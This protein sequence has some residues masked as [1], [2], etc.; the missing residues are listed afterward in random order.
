MIRFAIVIATCALVLIALLGVRTYAGE[1]RV[2]DEVLAYELSPNEPLRVRVPGGI[3]ELILTSWAVVTPEPRFD[4]RKPYRYTLGVELKGE[5]PDATPAQSLTLESRVS[6][7][8]ARPLAMGDFTARL[9]NS[10]E[11]LA[12]PRSQRLSLSALGKPGGFAVVRARGGPGVERV[13]V[14]LTYLEPLGKLEKRVRARALRPERG[15]RM[16]AGRSS[17]GFDDLPLAVRDRALE[18]WERRFPAVGREG[19][20][21]V[22]GSVLIGHRLPLVTAE[23]APRDDYAVGPLVRTGLNFARPL[24]LRLHGPPLAEI[25]VTEGASPAYS[26]LIGESGQADLALKGDSP[27]TISFGAP[28]TARLRFSVAFGD[29]RAQIGAVDSAL[30]EQ[31]VFLSPDVRIQRYYE[32]DPKQPVV[33][34]LAPGQTAVGLSVRAFVDGDARSASARISSL[35]ADGKPI[36]FEPFVDELEASLFDRVKERRVTL[37]RHALLDAPAGTVELAVYGELGTL[38][39]PFVREPGVLE[40]RPEADYDIELPEGMAWRHA[41]CID[42]VVAAVRAGNDAALD[43]DGRAVRVEATVRLEAE[44]SVGPKVVE[45]GA[46]PKGRPLVRTAFLP[47]SRPNAARVGDIWSF[48]PF[49]VPTAVLVPRAADSEPLSVFYRVKASVL[50]QP[51]AFS[52]DGKIVADDPVVVRSGRFRTDAGPGR[53][54]LLLSGADAGAGQAIGVAFASALSVKGGPVFQRRSVYE[55]AFG[56]ALELDFERKADEL[57]SLFVTVVREAGPGPVELR[58]AIDPKRTTPTPRKMYRRV[59]DAKGTAV[60]HALDR[61]RALLLEAEERDAGHPLPHAVAR[62]R[63]ELGDDLEVG[64]HVLRLEAPPSGKQAGSLW[65]RAVVAGRT[66][67]RGVPGAEEAP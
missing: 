38:V 32:L 59:T 60:I 51:L 61:D 5:V 24:G 65:V 41:P 47:S 36:A 52:V 23:G 11:W 1:D 64:E 31:R 40:D 45:R 44:H 34:R 10:E 48:L 16:V 8:P 28:A 55:L 56:R 49:G 30:G 33:V 18:N 39:T 67:Q 42:K 2:F 21:Y 25:E 26:V 3:D 4:P 17:L 53:H 37:A 9:G 19:V 50:G 29:E 20:D 58:Y 7:D 43:A 66:I 27:R 62:H 63:I 22:T 15:R 14:R 6:Y 35:A 57:L 12:D 54:E 13:M 46:E